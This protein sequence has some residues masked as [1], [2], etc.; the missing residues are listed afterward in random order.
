[1]PSNVNILYATVT[2]SDLKIFIYIHT[3]RKG[4]TLA[5]I[6]NLYWHSS[7]FFISELL[8]HFWRQLWWTN[9]SVPEHRHGLINVWSLLSVRSQWHILQNSPADDTVDIHDTLRF[10]SV[11]QLSEPWKFITC[12]F[13]LS[14]ASSCS[15]SEGFVGVLSED[16]MASLSV[17]A[18]NSCSSLA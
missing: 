3:F 14:L 13:S 9:I 7:H 8:I 12:I 10:M 18:K 16:A 6:T 1:M 5:S 11:R 15:Q 17:L 2:L 4:F